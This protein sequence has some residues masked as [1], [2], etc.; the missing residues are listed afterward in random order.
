MDLTDASTMRATACRRARHIEEGP[1]A[2]SKHFVVGIAF[3]SSSDSA[4]FLVKCW[5]RNKVSERSSRLLK[6]KE[7]GF[8]DR[9][10]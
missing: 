10:P 1:E 3:G 7:E 6:V 2:C 8:G 9:Q 4:A 5:N